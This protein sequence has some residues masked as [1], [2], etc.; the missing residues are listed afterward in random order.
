[1]SGTLTS[2]IGRYTM[3][4]VAGIGEVGL[5][6]CRTLKLTFGVVCHVSPVVFGD[7]A[8]SRVPLGH[9]ANDVTSTRW[10]PPPP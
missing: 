1:M 7:D 4:S 6:G 3:L 9:V 8:D 5:N 10:G 2:L